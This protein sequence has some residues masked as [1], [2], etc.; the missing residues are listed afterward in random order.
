MKPRRQKCQTR[1]RSVL[2]MVHL[3]NTLRDPAPPPTLAR[4]PLSE[5]VCCYR[6]NKLTTQ[7]VHPKKTSPTIPRTSK[8]LPRSLN[9][10]KHPNNLETFN[11][12][13]DAVLAMASKV[14]VENTLQHK[15]CYCDPR[16]R[17]QQHH[18]LAGRALD[19]VRFTQRALKHTAHSR[20]WVWDRECVRENHQR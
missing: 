1:L 14:Q 4:L 13:T 3:D 19:N 16:N 10:V 11:R 2:K 6:R 15:G 8:D 5:C 7:P 18:P 12:Q 9:N 20:A 17:M